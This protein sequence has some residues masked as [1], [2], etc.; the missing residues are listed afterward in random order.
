MMRLWEDSSKSVWS[1]SRVGS[2]S[3]SDVHSESVFGHR[4]APQI[5][6]FV[7][8]TNQFIIAELDGLT[9]WEPST[10]FNPFWNGIV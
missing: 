9:A 5:S 7:Q 2:S 4:F 6:F 8:P 1:H 10:C 3:V